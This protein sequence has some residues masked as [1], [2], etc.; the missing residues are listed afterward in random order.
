MLSVDIQSSRFI[1][2][3]YC[4]HEHINPLGTKGFGTHTK[5]QGGGGGW[6]GGRNGPTPVSQE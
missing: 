5:H 4:L 2:A 1:P 6:W 3:K